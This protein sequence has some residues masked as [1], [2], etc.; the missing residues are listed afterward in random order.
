M[1]VPA[2]EKPFLVVSDL[3]LG[4]VP[5]DTERRFR[6]FLDYAARESSGLLINGDLFEFGIAY[7]SAVPRGHVRVIAKLADVVESGV[8]VYF[9]GGNHDYLEWGGHV[10]REDA[11]VTLLP[12]P[13]VMEIAGRRA[14]ITHGD[15]VGAGATRERIERR[16]ARS[17]PVVAL[18]RLLH[19]DWVA[20]IQPFTT[21][22]RRQVNM[23]DSGEGGGPKTRAPGIEAWAREKLRDDASLDVV[24]AAHAHLPACV[25]VKPGRYYLNAGDWITH[26]TYL[27][28]PQRGAPE[29]RRWMEEGDREPTRR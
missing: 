9:V 14:L 24:I 4:G 19:P 12:D 16:L 11:G 10:L 25:E 6:A 13:T 3:H 8:P 28:M 22:T 23:H 5:G 26:F 7:R 17:R 20:R 27:L 18:L 1:S 29:L 2:K 21:T 15:A